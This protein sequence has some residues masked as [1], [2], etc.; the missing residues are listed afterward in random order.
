MY[1]NEG[2]LA[3][4]L[5]I[6][7]GLALMGHLGGMGDLNAVTPEHREELIHAL[8]DYTGDLGNYAKTLFGRA[9]YVTGLDK[10]LMDALIQGNPHYT[11]GL[12]NA[13][14]HEIPLQH[15]IDNLNNQLHISNQNNLM[16]QDTQKI[17]N[18][19]QQ[20]QTQAQSMQNSNSINSGIQN[21]THTPQS[22][23]I[24][25][26]AHQMT[27]Q[28]FNQQ[29]NNTNTNT[30]VNTNLNNQNHSKLNEILN[31]N[32][33]Y[34]TNTNTNTNTNNQNQNN[35]NTFSTAA[36]AAAGAAAGAGV[37]AGVGVKLASNKNSKLNSIL[38]QNNTNNNTNMNN[39]N[40]NTNNNTNM[41]NTNN[42]NQNNQKP[43]ND[44]ENTKENID[45]IKLIKKEKKKK[46]PKLLEPDNIEKVTEESININKWLKNIP[47]L[48]FKRF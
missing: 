14:I 39:I 16:D 36:A 31:Q 19:W 23:Y 3:N 11:E 10:P 27:N 1:L 22:Q 5:G 45:L 17:Y 47:Y 41:N 20:S 18:Q 29:N 43:L 24:N 4:I 21:L 44:S 40:N 15:Q 6:G 42:N 25:Q 34:N 30:N 7:A 9:A 2:A 26:Q 13:P 28:L 12:A 8:K 37:G 46:E 48:K 32:Q 33:Q 35:S 38:N